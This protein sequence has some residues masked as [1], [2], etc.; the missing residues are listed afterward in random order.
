M[1]STTT[2]AAVSTIPSGVR[3][4]GTDWDDIACYLGP[5]GNIFEDINFYIDSVKDS[6]GIWLK[7][8]SKFFQ[9]WWLRS[10]Y[11]YVNDY[12]CSVR[13]GGVVYHDYSVDYSYGR[14]YFRRALK[15]GM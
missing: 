10:P 8:T 3:S 2:T 12:A 6:Y 1:T 9:K 4:P 11:A 14:I 7:Y 15:V 5:N 13:S